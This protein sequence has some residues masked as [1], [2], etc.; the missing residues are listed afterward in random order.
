MP[1]HA[2]DGGKALAQSALEI[3]DAVG[4]LGHAHKWIDISV[5]IDDLAVRRFAHAHVVHI[6]N[7]A[8]LL[9]NARKLAVNRLDALVGGIAAGQPAG[10]QRLDMGLDLDLEPELVAHGLLE[11]VRY[12]MSAAERQA[13]I[14]LEIERDREPSRDGL[15]RHMMDG[16]RAV[17][18]N[19]HD[20][21]EHGLVV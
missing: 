2:L 16:E 11:P 7:D 20:A 18:R 4:D 14:N 19:H 12:L 21:L 8:M 5:E 1:D 3:V 15:H 9:R 10:L 13:A 6:A 17:A